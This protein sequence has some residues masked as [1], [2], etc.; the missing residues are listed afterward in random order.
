MKLCFIKDAVW[1]AKKPES[2]STKNIVTLFSVI[3]R[4]LTRKIRRERGGRAPASTPPRSCPGL[5]AGPTRYRTLHQCC[6]SG[7]CRIR[8]RIWP[9]CSEFAHFSSKWSSSKYSLI[10]YIF[11]QCCR[12]GP[13]PRKF[14]SSRRRVNVEGTVM[15]TTTQYFVKQYFINRP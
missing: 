3:G 14:F 11:P 13:I 15:Q 2:G 1:K 5:G 7:S 6:G 4:A 12:S 10:A 8:I 9:H